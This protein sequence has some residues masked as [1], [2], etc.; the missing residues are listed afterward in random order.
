MEETAAGVYTNSP[1]GAV[2]STALTVVKQR[3]E[4]GGGPGD[5]GGTLGAKWGEQ[6][7]LVG[8][9]I[10]RKSRK[11]KWVYRPF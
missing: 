9:S 7:S 3:G 11:E 4:M 6:L 8:Y 10:G 5:G 1:T 2:A